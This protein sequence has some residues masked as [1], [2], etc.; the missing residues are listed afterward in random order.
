M[1]NGHMMASV[2]HIPCQATS[3]VVA[4]QLSCDMSASALLGM[5]CVCNEMPVISL[6]LS[7][8]KGMH[9]MRHG[10]LNV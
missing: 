3:D 9:V 7:Y 8:G 5:T 1:T 4:S 10:Q 6:P 2:S